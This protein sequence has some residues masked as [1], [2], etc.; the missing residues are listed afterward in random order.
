MMAGIH[1]PSV[2]GQP[3]IPFN[4]RDMHL[5][6]ELPHNTCVR[7]TTSTVV[8]SQGRQTQPFALNIA[9]AGI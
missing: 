1:I 2:P 5:R 4:V 3:N 8:E 7:L 6:P 9:G